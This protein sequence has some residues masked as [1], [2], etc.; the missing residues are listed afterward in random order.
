MISAA[1]RDRVIFAAALALGVLGW[2]WAGGREAW[3]FPLYGALVLPVTYLALF[4]FG[5]LGSRGAWRWPA[6]AFGAQLATLLLLRAVKG[7]G[8]GNLAPLGLLIFGALATIGLAP[9]YLGV[10]LRRWRQKR[11][12]ARFAAEAR[13]AAFSASD[14]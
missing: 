4:F 7:Q 8:P 5:L 6:L 12:A 1:A 13:R 3:D 11:R 10:A 9:A 14:S 2:A